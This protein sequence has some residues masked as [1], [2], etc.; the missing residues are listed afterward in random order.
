MVSDNRSCLYAA[1]IFKRVSEV[2]EEN[3]ALALLNSAYKVSSDTLW[4]M[5]NLALIDLLQ[6]YTVFKKTSM[7]VT[8]QERVLAIDG[9]YIHVCQFAPTTAH[10]ILINIYHSTDHAIGKAC[11]IWL[12]AHNIFPHQICCC[13]PTILQ[14]ISN[15]QAG[16]W[17]GQW[18]PQAVW[19]RGREFQIG[20][21]VA[22]PPIISFWVS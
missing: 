20:T 10:W 7:L 4:S 8:R 18:K 5:A 21:W 11:S 19:L 6:K 17:Q 12:W 16:G 1:S 13:L 15:V 3:A 22:L 9:D 2:P 14:V